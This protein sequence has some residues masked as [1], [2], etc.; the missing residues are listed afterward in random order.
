MI[1]QLCRRHDDDAP[2]PVTFNLRVEAVTDEVGKCLETFHSHSSLEHHENSVV[3][4][5][6]KKDG[7]GGV[8]RPP[9]GTALYYA[10]PARSAEPLT[11]LG[12]S[13]YDR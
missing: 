1:A 3:N 6:N 8:S 12:P 4:H 10:R 9:A 13:G 5:E 7:E 2:A 11:G